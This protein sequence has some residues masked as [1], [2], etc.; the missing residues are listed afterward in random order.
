M[1]TSGCRRRSKM[2]RRNRANEVYPDESPV[3]APLVAGAVARLLGGNA[4]FS[5]YRGTGRFNGFCFFFSF[6]P[7]LF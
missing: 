2:Q 5:T 6:L 4:S 1:R 3:R 7:Q